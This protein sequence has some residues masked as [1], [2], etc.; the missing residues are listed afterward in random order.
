MDIQILARALRCCRHHRALPPTVHALR[1]LSEYN[2]T[3]ART[4][5]FFQLLS[6]HISTMLS[7]WQTPPSGDQPEEELAALRAAFTVNNLAH[8]Q[9]SVLFWRYFHPHRPIPIS[10]LA[11]LIGGDLDAEILRQRLREG[12]GLLAEFLE[13]REQNALRQQQQAR[14][15]RARQRLH[16]KPIQAQKQYIE[17]LYDVLQDVPRLYLEGLG[18]IGKS[19]LA[20]YLCEHLKQTHHT[21][22]INAQP[23]WLDPHGRLRVLPYAARSAAEI[24]DQLWQQLGFSAAEL[25]SMAQQLAQIGTFADSCIVVIDGLD[26]VRD[27]Q[28]LIDALNTLPSHCRFVL[29]TRHAPHDEGGCVIRLNE[30]PFEQSKHITRA[31]LRRATKHNRQRTSDLSDEQWELIYST[32]GG[33]PLALTL[34]GYMLA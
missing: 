6:N 15:G 11:K 9:W 33:V 31:A 21:I 4:K 12:L 13:E 25:L 30:L 29:T 5:A 1:C 17:R 2:G 19:S 20:F 22:W 3:Q 23:H 7:R 26:H 8:Q 24:I 27:E 10:A 34:L 18:G 16:S 28:N 14:Q 32:V